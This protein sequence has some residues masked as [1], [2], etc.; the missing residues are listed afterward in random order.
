YLERTNLLQQ[1]GDTLTEVTAELNAQIAENSEL[2]RQLDAQQDGSGQAL[3]LQGVL[4]E[5]EKI[6]TEL[7]AENQTLKDQLETSTAAAAN[8]NSA[9]AVDQLTEKVGQLEASLALAGQVNADMEAKL[10]DSEN[11]ADELQARLELAEQLT[12]DLQSRLDA[13]QQTSASPNETDNSAAMSALEQQLKQAEQINTELEDRLNLAEQVTSQLQTELTSAR[14]T[15]DEA[16]RQAETGRDSSANIENNLKQAEAALKQAEEQVSSTERQKAEA[17]ERLKLAEQVN[18]ALQAQLDNAV[19]NDIP[20]LESDLAERNEQLAVLDKEITRLNTQLD[21]L[22]DTKAVDSARI[23]E[24]RK[25]ADAEIASLNEELESIRKL[26]EKMDAENATLRGQ[27]SRLETTNKELLS[28]LETAKQPDVSPQKDAGN[29]PN[30]QSPRT[31]RDPL[32]VATA[33]KGATGLQ[34]LDNDQRDRIATRLI[35]G[36]CV[37]ETLQDELGRVSPITLRDLIRAFESDC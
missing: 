2:K 17:D 37:G 20:S 21:Q 7:R 25:N 4:E 23:T 31:P 16:G 30:Q 28:S 13:A 32:L 18:N 10:K 29:T 27:V 26:A 3:D 19:K 6:V 33:M 36:D 14:Q 1:S 24:T 34:D 15:A 11:A 8:S 12:N 35:E 9:D 5:Q 22:A